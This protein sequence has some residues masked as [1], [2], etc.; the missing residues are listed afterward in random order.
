LI[1]DFNRTEHGVRGAWLEHRP[2]RDE[3]H[4]LAQTAEVLRGPAARL[5]VQLASSSTSSS[6]AH[7]RP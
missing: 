5:D 1:G 3:A 2:A 7:R 6:H 4:A